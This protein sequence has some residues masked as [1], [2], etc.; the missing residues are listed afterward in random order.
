VNGNLIGGN[1]FTTDPVPSG[2]ATSVKVID[3]RKCRANLEIQH[4]CEEP[5]NLPC[6][7][8][9]IRCASRLWLQRPEGDANYKAYKQDSAIKLIFNNQDIP[10][11]DTTKILQMTVNALN[12]N[13]DKAITNAIKKLNDVINTAMVAAL[14]DAGK[15]RLVFSPAAPG[16]APFPFDV[17]LIEHFAC[18]TFTLEFNYSYAKPDPAY[19]LTVRYTSDPTFSGMV[20]VNRRL[21]NKQTRVPAFACAQRNLCTHTDFKNLCQG[22][23]PKTVARFVRDGNDFQC[24]GG[25]DN[26]DEVTVI[27]WVWDMVQA[28]PSEPFYEGRQ[29]TAKLQQPAGAIGLTAITKDGCFGRAESQI[30]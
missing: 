20:I 10:L 8:D 24:S 28:H 18:E 25:I 16:A 21:D 7:G 2:T 29:V 1:T 11:P 23:D 13:F 27:A 5:C 14:G 22:P 6:G 26:P 12:S 9:S 30:A 19:A 17:M 4:T 3:S 15:D